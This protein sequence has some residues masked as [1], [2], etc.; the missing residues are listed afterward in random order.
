ML[1][2]CPLHVRVSVCMFMLW[3]FKT[4]MLSAPKP[5][6]SAPDECWSVFLCV[7]L[8]F[9]SLT[10]TD[11]NHIKDAQPHIAF[12]PSPQLLVS[13]CVEQFSLQLCPQPLGGD[14]HPLSSPQVDP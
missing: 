6:R 10:H 11:N 8:L 1:L 5:V 12:I 4:P 9:C 3:R 13:L 2:S 7:R 14:H